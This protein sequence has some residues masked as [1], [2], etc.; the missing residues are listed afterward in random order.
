MKSNG[1]DSVIVQT[2]VANGPARALYEKHGF[3]LACPVVSGVLDCL[4]TCKL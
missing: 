2:R 4:Y 3:T 1:F